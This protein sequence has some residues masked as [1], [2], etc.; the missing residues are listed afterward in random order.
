MRKMNRMD[1]LDGFEL[2]N[3]AAFNKKIDSQTRSDC[4]V[5]ISYGH[6]Q[7]AVES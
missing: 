1:L 7:F 4:L 5:T 6:M 2:Y 3:D